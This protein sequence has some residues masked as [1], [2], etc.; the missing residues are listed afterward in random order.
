MIHSLEYISAHQGV[1]DSCTSDDGDIYAAITPLALVVWDDDAAMC[2]TLPVYS[3]LPNIPEPTYW[4]R[5]T[6]GNDCDL[7]IAVYEA[8]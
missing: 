8:A 7:D 4:L 2:I 1:L 5:T 6:D 3:C